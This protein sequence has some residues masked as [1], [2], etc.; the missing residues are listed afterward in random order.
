MMEKLS[1]H[2]EI[3]REE[4]G[5][6]WCSYRLLCE[7]DPETGLPAYGIECSLE[8][9]REPKLPL[10][11]AVVRGISPREEVVEQ[12]IWSLA[13]G[14]ALPVHIADIVYDLLG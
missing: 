13:R 8:G 3:P 1:L 14:Q 12:M 10:N 4:G 9:M 7:A 5:S 2:T 11:R 6:L